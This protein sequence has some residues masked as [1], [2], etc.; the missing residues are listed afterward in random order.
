MQLKNPLLWCICITLSIAQTNQ[1]NG[2]DLRAPAFPLITHDPYYSIWSFS[3]TLNNQATKHWT[4]EEQPLNILAQ[5]DGT[6]FQLAGSTFTQIEDIVPTG[7][8]ETYM[9]RCLH[10]PPPK[11]WEK[12]SFSDFS[13]ELSNGPFGDNSASNPLKPATLFQRE[14]WYRREFNLSKIPKDVKL[15]ISHDDAAEVFLNGEPIYNNSNYRA[16]Y[17]QEDIPAKGLA[18]L[19]VGKN[20]LAVHCLNTGGGAF[21]DFGLVCNKNL[22]STKR[23]VQTGVKLTATQTAYSFFAGGTAISLTFTSPLLLDQLAILARPASYI[24]ISAKSQDAKK[25][26]VKCWI[27]LSGR[28]SANTREQQV[29][30]KTYQDDQL[31]IQSVGTLSQHTLEKRGDNLRIDWGEAYLAIEKKVGNSVMPHE[32]ME[33]IKSLSSRQQVSK[34]Q[35]HGDAS[36]TWI[37]VQIDMGRISKQSVSTHAIL[38]YD[39]KYSVQYFGENLR[40]WWRRDEKVT[41]FDML[42]AAERD[43]SRLMQDCRAFDNKLTA[44]AKKAG[45]QKY[46]QLCELAYRQAIAAHKIVVN[47][48]GELLFFSKENFSNGCIGTVD[49]TYPSAPL[50]LLYNT[51]LVKGLLRFIIDYSESGKWTKPFPAH[52]LGVFPQANGQAYGADMPVEEA[53]NMLILMAAIAVRDGNADFAKSHW[54]ILTTWVKYLKKEGLDPANQL[55]TDDFAGHLARNANLSIKAIM[56]IAAYGKMAQMLHKDEI[57]MENMDEAHLLARTWMTLANDGDHYALAFGNVNTWSQKYNLVWDKLLKLN[58]FPKEVAE[59]ELAFYK[60][61]QQPYGLPLDS[62]KT[63]SKSD[64]ILWTAT[65]GIDTDFQE[66]VDPVWKFANETSDR[67]PLS[68]WYETTNGRS[69]AFRA[70]SVVGGYFVKMLDKSME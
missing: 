19:K 50:F 39:D 22:L 52:D 45:G 9:A 31:L 2:Q 48:H 54:E 34:V 24:T 40:P 37:G 15:L 13:W 29:A 43:Y 59:K 12:P 62:R 42:H 26:A 4:G 20:L 21:A 66:F 46:A 60:T 5:V 28:I 23:A 51:E 49:V 65:L 33:F 47:S 14:I 8:K 25:H 44:D 41:A 11:G 1:T 32:T 30:A 6:L 38:A 27:A 53:G 7:R 68:D 70:R 57:A 56:G 67:I 58:I 10:Q 17:T 61:K 69:I 35:T 64:W 55:C 16:D 18:T 36:S 63:Y 3:D